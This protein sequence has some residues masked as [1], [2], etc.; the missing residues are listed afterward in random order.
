MFGFEG[1]EICVWY[2]VFRNLIKYLFRYF[3]R[4]LFILY[5]RFLYLF[6]IYLDICLIFGLVLYLLTSVY[7][8]CISDPRYLYHYTSYVG[9]QGAL[10]H[11]S[12]PP[13]STRLR[14]ALGTQALT[15]TSGGASGIGRDGRRAQCLRYFGLVQ[16]LER[17]E[18][19]MEPSLDGTDTILGSTIY[20]LL[21]P[22]SLSPTQ[23]E[24]RLLNQPVPER[25]LAFSE[26]TQRDEKER[27]KSTLLQ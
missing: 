24:L 12:V 20:R 6:S 26:P 7:G 19:V 4:H 21:S 11:F 5:I 17:V 22:T 14:P 27:E 9:S 10:L 1:D 2:M 16:S 8:C 15:T 25:I 3:P 18:C 23:L 13:P